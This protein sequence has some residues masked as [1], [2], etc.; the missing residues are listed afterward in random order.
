M[1]I[2][3][4]RN[5][6]LFSNSYIVVSEQL[7]TAIIIDPGKIT[8]DII[9]QLE[10]NKYKMKAA[11]IT[12][13]H[14]GHTK[15]LFSLSRIYDIEIYAADSEIAGLRTNV[16]NGEGFLSVA[17]INIAYFQI[18][19]FSSDS[20]VYKIENVLF[21]GDAIQAGKIGNTTS[22]YSNVILK[23]GLKS[24]ILSQ[25]PN[26]VIMSSHGPLTTV[27]AERCF[28]MDL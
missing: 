12:H 8:S 20:M 11:L 28:N 22:S 6:E 21:T 10:D 4:H 18:P 24:K 23:R 14:E 17:G 7:K 2:Y 9:N 13:N 19:G 3:F 26:T 25:P 27:A 16:I 15:G 5:I 1:K